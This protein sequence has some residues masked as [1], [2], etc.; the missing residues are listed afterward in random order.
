[1]LKMYRIIPFVFILF[2]FGLTL[3]PVS[4]VF[5]EDSAEFVACQKIKPA[6]DFNLMKRKKNCFRDVARALQDQSGNSMH[7]VAPSDPSGGEVAQLNAKIAELEF[8]VA[9]LSATNID[10]KKRTDK[11]KDVDPLIHYMHE[12]LSNPYMPWWSI[13]DK[14]E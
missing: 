13:S 14:N 12:R 1:M 3:I 4:P 8:Q 6:G 7:T 10:L 2:L 5:A 9:S 11:K